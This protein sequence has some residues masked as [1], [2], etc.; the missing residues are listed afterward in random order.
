M[1]QRTGTVRSPTIL[2]SWVGLAPAQE[3]EERVGVPVHVE[4]D[5]VLGAYGERQLGAGRDHSD[6]LYVKASGGI[7]ASMV[8]DGAVYAGAY[9]LAGEIGHTQLP[10]HTELCRC[11]NRGCLEA[12]RLTVRTLSDKGRVM[13]NASKDNRSKSAR[14][15]HDPYAAFRVPYLSCIHYWLVYCHVGHTYPERCHRLGNVSTHGGGAF[16]RICRSGASL[17]HHVVGHPRGLSWPI[18]ASISPKLVM[19]SLAAMTV[20]SLGLAV[21]SYTRGSVNAMY[22]LLFLD[23]AA[24]MIGRPAARVALVPQLVPAQVFPNAVTWNTS[25]MQIAGVLGPAIGGFVLVVNL[26]LAY[27]ITAAS[28]LLFIFLL[29]AAE[30]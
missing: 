18:V 9:G 25:L 5:A 20:T 4:N 24:V 8:L 23:A 26:P 29:L 16:A 1:D 12:V 15:A 6:F 27:V 11:G 7:G 21:L 2:S 28:S 19:I 3:L 22:L 17:A 13:S 30:L 14:P 10:G